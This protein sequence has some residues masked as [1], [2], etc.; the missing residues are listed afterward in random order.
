LPFLL[1]ILFSFSC[2]PFFQNS[3]TKSRILKLCLT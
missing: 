3:T 1:K 2:F